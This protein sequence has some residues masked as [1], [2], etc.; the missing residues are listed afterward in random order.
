MGRWHAAAAVGTAMLASALLGCG[1]S[2][3]PHPDP[4][5]PAAVARAW[6]ESNLKCQNPDIQ[7]LMRCQ[8]VPN[9]EVGARVV[10]RSGDYVLVATT[11]NGARAGSL[12]V[13]RRGRGYV[14]SPRG[15]GS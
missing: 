3:A 15:P 10:R 12:W 13:V 6:V 1:G 2:S 4:H 14:I 11:V 5:D 9:L 7:Y 8:P